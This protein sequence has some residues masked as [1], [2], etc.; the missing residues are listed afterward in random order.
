MID[1]DLRGAGHWLPRV[2]FSAAVLAFFALPASAQSLSPWGWDDAPR[3]YRAPPADYDYYDDDDRYAP[4]PYRYR[5][6]YRDYRDRRSRYPRGDYGYDRYGYE[7]DGDG[8]DE[9]P[10]GAQEGRQRITSDGGAKPNILP[11]AP[12]VMAFSGSYAP[13]SIVIDT[14]ARKLYYVIDGTKAFVYPIGVGRQGFSWN[15]TE[16]VSRIAKWPDWYPPAEMRQRQPYLP[17]RM[18]GGVRNPLGAMAIYL[19]NTLYRIHGTND[20]KSIGRAESSGCFRMMNQHVVH[21][22]SRVQIGASVTVVK[23]LKPSVSA[24]AAQA[25]PQPDGSLDEFR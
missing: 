13:G 23:S 24:K 1:R 11:V 16:K 20:A 21:L 15:G 9:P 12:P 6:D 14:G 3:R 10:S 25:K 22:A 18:L 19:G 8:F 17:E 5:R 4:Q 2:I 7:Y